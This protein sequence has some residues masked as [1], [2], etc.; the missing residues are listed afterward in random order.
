MNQT[1]EN[2]IKNEK[3]LLK[4]SPMQFCFEVY[5]PLLWLM[6]RGWEE[7]TSHG[8]NISIETVFLMH[9]I[10]VLLLLNKAVANIFSESGSSTRSSRFVLFR[11]LLQ[12]VFHK[13]FR[14]FLAV[15]QNRFRVET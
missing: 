2:K 15:K 4:F 9:S 14:E 3:N 12:R 5:V 8:F 6:S 7:I 11:L 13:S 10:P 1:T